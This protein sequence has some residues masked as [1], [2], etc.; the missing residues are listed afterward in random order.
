MRSG[1]SDYKII[2]VTP[3]LDT[4]EYDSGDV[5][6]HSLEIPDAVI[7]LGGCSK[8]VAMFVVSQ[9]ATDVD[10]EFIFS[11]NTLAL[12]TQNATADV[13]DSAIEAAN[14]TGHL[15]LDANEGKTS[16]IDT[17]KIFRVSDAGNASANWGAGPI[18]LQA[19]DDSTSV[20]V[21]GLGGATVT[22][23]ADDIDLILHLER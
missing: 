8:L 5:L 22:Y 11:E 7:G 20:Y 21:G 13:A 10:M 16:H 4:N 23:A 9:N 17:S 18:L 6:F 1:K 2:R 3:T 19:A 14:I 15:V 12:G